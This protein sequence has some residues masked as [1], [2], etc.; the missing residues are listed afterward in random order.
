MFKKSLGCTADKV[1]DYHDNSLSELH[2]FLTLLLL[3]SAVV[4]W[5]YRKP[6]V[7]QHQISMRQKAYPAGPGLEP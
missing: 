4:Q 3:A 6:P 1:M 5:V 7:I 2:Q